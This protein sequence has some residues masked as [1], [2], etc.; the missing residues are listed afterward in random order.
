MGSFGLIGR[1]NV[2]F[3]R[4]WK[5][6]GIY[7][8]A[9][10]WKVI[11]PQQFNHYL[12]AIKNWGSEFSLKNCKVNLGWNIVSVDNEIHYAWN[13][14]LVADFFGIGPILG[15]KVAWGQVVQLKWDWVS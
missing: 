15:I 10:L 3:K 5:D 8:K 1:A 14:T 12:L 4:A 11:W 7:H 2:N 6:S 13:P 9:Y